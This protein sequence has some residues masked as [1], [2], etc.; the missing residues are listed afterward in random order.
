MCQAALALL[1]AYGQTVPVKELEVG[2]EEK[3]DQGL[4]SSACR[5]Q[6]HKFT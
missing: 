6:S 1:G 4:Q 3:T 2:G 5:R